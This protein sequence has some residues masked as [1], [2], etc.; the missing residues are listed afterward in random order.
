MGQA[1]KIRDTKVLLR[2]DMDDVQEMPFASGR[3]AYFTCRCPDKATVSEDALGIFD[4][5]ETQGVLVL[6]DGCGG[7][8]GGEVAAETVIN[9]VR[10]K[11]ANYS[12]TDSLR[13]AVLD[14]LELANE[15]IRALGKGAA[16][17]VIVA[18]VEHNKIRSIHAGDSQ[19]LII[20]GRGKVKMQTVSHSPVGYGVEAGLIDEDEAIDHEDRHLVSNIVGSKS[21][22]F[23]IGSPR[24]M[25]E[26][27]TL[28]LGSDGVFD[29]FLE[30]ELARLAKTSPLLNAAS[31]IISAA[32][33]RMNHEEPDVP[34]KA[35]D[36][37]LLMFRR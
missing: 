30:G 37:S 17:T 32:Q 19:A 20:G 25:A 31:E 27:D 3:V 22:H 10:R 14:G 29:N 16:T 34:S 28:L 36:L 15:A 5:S 7:M 18:L 12:S 23:E 26:R 24:A 9:E 33:Y 2:A 8:Q 13:S 21:T 11:L 1:T 35:D 4:L 6:T